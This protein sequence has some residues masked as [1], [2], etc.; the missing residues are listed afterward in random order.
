MKDFVTFFKRPDL[1]QP[2]L[3]AAW[4]GMGNVALG[5]MKYL[6]DHL[7]ATLIGEVNA[8]HFFAPTSALVSKQ[9][10]RPP[11]IPKNQIFEY[12]GSRSNQSILFYLGSAQPIPHRE[13]AFAVELLNMMKRIGVTTVY[14]AAAA[15]SDMH[16]KSAPRIFAAPNQSE[17]LIKMTGEGV[18]FMSDGNIAGLNGLL[19]AVARELGIPGMCL[20]GEIPF[21]TAQVEFPRASL[22]VLHVL[23]KQLEI[24]VDLVDLELAAEKKEKELEPLANLLSRGKSGEEPP[25]HGEQVV[26][27]QEEKIPQSVRSRIEKLFKQAEFDRTYKSKMR[28]KEELDRWELFDDYLDR[29]LDLFKKSTGES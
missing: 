24:D 27:Q 11:D 28:L 21:F 2:V 15:P 20:L 6:K 13:Y 4:P 1:K 26:P 12:A 5:A 22:E 8:Q 19:I 29:F 14:T 18:H 3:L 23:C 7:E 9:L 25:K 17:L 10:I 16:F